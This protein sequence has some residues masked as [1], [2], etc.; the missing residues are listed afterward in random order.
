MRAPGFVISLI[1]LGCNGSTAASTTDGGVAPD[2]VTTFK[3]G[4]WVSARGVISFQ[5]DEA[6]QKWVP[7]ITLKS[8]DDINPTESTNDMDGV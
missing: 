8:N 1:F 5:R 2:A 6:K 4:D 3:A 7:V